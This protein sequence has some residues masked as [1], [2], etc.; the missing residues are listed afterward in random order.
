MIGKTFISLKIELLCV[1]NYC[2]QDKRWGD[3][4][5]PTQR[6]ISDYCYWGFAPKG[7]RGVPIRRATPYANA[8]RAFSPNPT[9]D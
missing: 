4:E 3:F 1:E 2:P 6:G 5:H 8:H 9:F 7:V